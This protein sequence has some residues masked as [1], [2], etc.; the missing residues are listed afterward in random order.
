MIVVGDKVVPQ[1]SSVFVAGEPES[2]NARKSGRSERAP[3]VFATTLD[4]GAGGDHVRAC[5][6]G[7]LLE[8]VVEHLRKLAGLAVVRLVVAPGRARV[9]QLRL[10]AV[11]LGR[12]LESEQLV[13]PE[14]AIGDVTRQR[15]V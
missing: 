10:D 12:H 9:E 15:R 2:P 3:R 8:V 13:R 5:L 4:A 14:L 11:H 7:E 6:F 1:D